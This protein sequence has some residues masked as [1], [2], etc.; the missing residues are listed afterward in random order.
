M[1]FQPSSLPAPLLP[2]ER[3]QEWHAAAITVAMVVTPQALRIVLEW[4]GGHD[5]PPVERSVALPRRRGLDRRP[6][7]RPPRSC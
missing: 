2:W 3:R 1:T 5:R 4:T 7:V 6:G